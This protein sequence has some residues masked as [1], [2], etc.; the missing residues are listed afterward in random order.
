MA[1]CKQMRESEKRRHDFVMLRVE[2]CL[3]V[4]ETFLSSRQP[5]TSGEDFPI[6][7]DDSE[8]VGG[9]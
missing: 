7:V 3:L 6:K 8:N 5:Q 4:T 2:I 9:F 1:E